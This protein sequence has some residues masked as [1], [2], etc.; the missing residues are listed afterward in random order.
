MVE[1]IMCLIKWVA[2]TSARWLSCWILQCRSISVMKVVGSYSWWESDTI[3]LA[4]LIATEERNRYGLTRWSCR[5]DSASVLYLL[6]FSCTKTRLT[7][8]SDGGL[9]SEIWLSQ[10]TGE[11]TLY[12]LLGF[13]LLD[14]T[15]TLFATTVFHLRLSLKCSWGSGKGKVSFG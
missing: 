15:Q 5:L 3:K 10:N 9:P 14:F 1:K 11:T 7:T 2:V 6:W 13:L 4:Q 12:L 8:I